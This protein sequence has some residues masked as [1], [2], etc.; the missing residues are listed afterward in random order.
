MPIN[1]KWWKVLAVINLVALLLLGYWQCVT[2]QWL[3][4]DLVKGW[5]QQ[6]GFVYDDPGPPDPTKPPP[7]PPAF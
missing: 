4:D 7:P 2:W 1:A 5:I 3:R 6:H